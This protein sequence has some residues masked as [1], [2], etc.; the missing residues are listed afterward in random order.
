MFVPAIVFFIVDHKKIFTYD[1][2]LSISLTVED[3]AEIY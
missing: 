3:L 1:I 2:L